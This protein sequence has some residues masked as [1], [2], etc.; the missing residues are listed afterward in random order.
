MVILDSCHTKD[1]VLKEL[2]AYHNLVTPGSYIVAT[3]GFV[4]YLFKGEVR[5]YVEDL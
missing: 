5:L 2:E 3:D 1:H 4:K